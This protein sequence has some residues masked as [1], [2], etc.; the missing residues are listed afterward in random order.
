MATKRFKKNLVSLLNLFGNS[1]ELLDFLVTKK[2]FSEEFMKQITMSDYLKHLKNYEDL[3]LQEIKR[4]LQ[5][6][7]AYNNKK[8]KISVDITKNDIFSY[9]DTEDDLIKKMNNYILNEDYERAQIMKRYFKTIELD[10]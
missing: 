3:D 10:Y 9:Q 4:K 7:I 5:Y 6:E 8:K 1:E 2:A